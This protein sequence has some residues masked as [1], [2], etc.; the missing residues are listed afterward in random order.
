MKILFLLGIVG[1]A[2]FIA[3]L[4][5]VYT[6]YYKG[7]ESDHFDGVRF[8]NPGFNDDKSN[9]DLR[10][11]QK[12]RVPTVWP[13]HVENKGY[14]KP[15]VRVE[16]D[17]LHVTFVGHATFLIQTAGLNILTDPFLSDRASP[18]SFIGPKRVRKPGLLFDEIPPIDVILVSHNHYDHLDRA[19]L[20][21]LINRDDPLI[22]TPLGNDALISG[23]RTL[24]WGQGVPVKEGVTITL[25]QAYHWSARGIYDRRKAL[26]GAFVIQTPGGPIYFGG[27]TGYR[28]GATFKRA[29]T[30]YGPFRLSLLPIGAYSPRWFMATSHM[31]PE[32]AV[33]AHMHLNSKF[34]LGMHFQ[35]LQLTDEG[36]EDP[37]KELAQGLAKTGI[38]PETF[39]APDIGQTFDIR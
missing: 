4:L 28:D 1:I 23:A 39:I 11:W 15:P 30:K 18:L 31:D 33:Q 27:D 20:R 34:S 14:E 16:G 21:K 10:K 24:D 38:P 25:E 13:V 32:Q 3:R 35:T 26:W 29:G 17:T 2:I 22:L 37:A 12:E 8:F 5:A 7:P 19:T 6:T 36:I 9:A